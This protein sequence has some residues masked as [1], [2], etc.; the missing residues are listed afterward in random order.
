MT[1]D[2]TEASV[3]RPCRIT[4]I[5]PL[6]DEDR[7]AVEAH[8]LRLPPEDRALRFACALSD[9]ALVALAGSLP[10]TGSLG[11]F[12][13]GELVGL[14][15]LPHVSDDEVEFGVSVEPHARAYGWGRALLRA[16][17]E[18]SYASGARQL[19]A[20]YG[21]T[22]RPMVRMMGPIP[23]AVQS[24]GPEIVAHVGLERWADDV[25]ASNQLIEAAT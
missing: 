2:A 23:K 18:A 6:S 4:G 1:G 5:A 20:Y 13:G 9:E 15:H 12:L 17:L 22:N 8:L 21:A 7:P 3:R 16:S 11:L 10:L 14:A 24:S 25:Y 19:T